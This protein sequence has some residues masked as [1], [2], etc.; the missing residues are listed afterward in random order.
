[1][2]TVYSW[3]LQNFGKKINFQLHNNY[4]GIHVNALLTDYERH[5][6]KLL[7][8]VS[9]ILLGIFLTYSLELELV[10]I[11]E[12]V[13]CG[14]PLGVVL[15]SEVIGWEAKHLTLDIAACLLLRQKET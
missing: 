12:G 14:H 11:P 7:Q 15:V 13:G 9:I 3:I 5:T 2:Y 10:V 8:L 1:M 6:L 4:Y